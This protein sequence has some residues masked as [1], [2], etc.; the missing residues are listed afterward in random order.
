MFGVFRKLF[1]LAALRR[2][3]APL[4]HDQQVRSNSVAQI[5][6]LEAPKKESLNKRTFDDLI[7]PVE[8]PSYLRLIAFALVLFPHT[9]T[10]LP[11]V[12]MNVEIGIWIVWMFGN[13]VEVQ[14]DT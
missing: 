9:K 4:P 10:T 5:Q 11:S 7:R 2:Q 14:F 3:I 6:G 8:C 13:D 12:L 1:A